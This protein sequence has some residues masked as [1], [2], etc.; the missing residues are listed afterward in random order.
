MSVDWV[1][2]VPSIVYTRIITEFS[3]ALKTEYKMTDDNFS[4]IGSSDTPPVFPFVYI[5]TLPGAEKGMDL[6]G[7]DINGGLFAFQIDVTDNKS[8]YRA[9]KVMAEIIRIMKTM[10]FEVNQFPKP[11]DTKDTHR[12][13]ARFRRIIGAIDTL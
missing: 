11:E 4:T 6:E 12:M 10:R 8:Q 13:I 7:T 5:N 1:S 2:M 9:R 3:K